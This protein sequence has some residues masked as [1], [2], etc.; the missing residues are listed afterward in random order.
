[1]DFYA[2]TYRTHPFVDGNTYPRMCF[3]CAHVPEE[4]QQ[5]YDSKGNIT[6]EM[7]P[8][9]DFKHL[10]TAQELYHQG[11]T[12][13]LSEAQK[14]VAGVRQKIKE[15]GG[16][17]KLKKL[18][19]KRP[20]HDYGQEEDDMPEKS[21]KKT[22]KK[23]VSKKATQPRGPKKAAPKKAAPKKKAAKK[24]KFGAKK[25]PRKKSP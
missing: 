4:F 2:V 16:P 3:G 13:S 8:F 17:V 10:V 1:M 23:R 15:A 20:P 21:P 24:V 11:S 19:L 12:E 7:G 25:P 22:R 18:K 6:E 9:F 5:K 14:C